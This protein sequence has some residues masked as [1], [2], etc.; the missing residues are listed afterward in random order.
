MTG[1]LLAFLSGLALLCVMLSSA[2]QAEPQCHSNDRY[3]VVAE[4]YPEDAG[5]QF[6]V[7][8]LRGPSGE[9]KCVAV[10]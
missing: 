10:Q 5:S 9:S 1:P 3:H 8:R 6:A 2:S 7:T 4:P